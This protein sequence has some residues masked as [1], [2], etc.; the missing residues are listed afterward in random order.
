MYSSLAAF[1]N[2]TFNIDAPYFLKGGF[3]LTFS[4]AISIGSGLVTTALFAHYLSS[5]N[6]GIYRYLIGLAALFSAFSLTGIGQSIL[7]TAAKKY[8]SFYSETLGLNYLFNIGVILSSLAAAIYYWTHDNQVLSLGCLI[9]AI[10]QP[11][12]NVFQYTPSY[13]QGSRR[14]RESTIAQ[15]VRTILTSTGSV[16]VLFF[17]NNILALFF[18]YLFFSAIVNILTHFWYRPKNTAATPPDILEK[19]ISYAKNN[20]LR[21]LVSSVASRA[22]SIIIFTQL[23]ASELAV[24][25][26]A[27]LI[28]EQVK[29]TFK[30]LASL[31]LP[32]YV[33]HSDKKVILRSIPKRS[34]QIGALLLIITILY[35][36]TAPYVLELFFPKYIS[37]IPYSQIYALS[38]LS[39]VSLIPMTAIQSS[40]DEKVLNQI[41][42]QSTLLGLLFILVF[43]TQFGIMGAIVARVLTR[44]VNSIYIYIKYFKTKSA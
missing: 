11:I 35:I 6:Y 17:T 36:V 25:S 44:Y 13:L 2:K 3:W 34:L 41:N 21:N 5:E 4:Q 15:G 43:T 8:Y 37:A 1:I 10:L 16:I 42:N 32:K 28:P 26:I 40:L 9:I 24:Y 12:S 33:T 38:F 14:F 27:T 19:Y 20:S 23:G 39:F 30:N 22:D 31:L 7:Q 29:G 18:S